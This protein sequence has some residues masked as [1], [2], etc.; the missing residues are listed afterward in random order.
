MK[1]TYFFLV[2]VIAFSLTFLLIYAFTWN[3]V[4]VSAKDS[5]KEFPTPT[6]YATSIPN[7]IE[8]KIQPYTQAEVSAQT[9]RGVEMVAT[10]FRIENGEFMADICFQTPD[11][12]DWV[13]HK[14]TARF[15]NTE[16]VP[17]GG[18]TFETV[19][20]LPNGERYLV[21][22]VGNPRV[23][24]KQSI[25]IDGMPD[26]RCDTLIF[27]I[28][29]DLNLSTSNVIVTIYAVGGTPREGQECA[30]RETIQSILDD[31]K[32]GI[33]IA[34]RQESFGARTDILEKPQGMS[35]EE[36]DRH[37]GEAFRQAFVIEGPWVF[38]GSVT[39]LTSP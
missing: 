13:T 9:V 23:V 12:N 31:K 8:Q 21:T 14:V 33:K 18:T 30:A 19:Y 35:E 28:S 16:L 7:F 26:Y 15:G 39:T 17:Y 11:N 34:C 32:L 4:E 24:N 6:P 1:K 5:Y 36:V 3:K 2:S 38:Q 22:N 37:I 10:N 29:S 20:T 27:R 25:P